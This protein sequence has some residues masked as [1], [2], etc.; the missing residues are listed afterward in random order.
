M[1]QFPVEPKITEYFHQIASRKKIPLNGTFE[2]TPVCNMSCRMC[3]VRMTKAQQEAIR[4]LHTAQEWLELGRIARDKG[5]LYLLLTGGEPFLRED[6]RQILSG[7]HQLGL[8]ISVNTNGTLIDEQAVA[9]LKKTPPVRFNITL[10]GASNE[11]YA[12]LCGNPNGFTQVTKAIRLLREAGMLVKLNCSL[13]PYNQ[14]DLEDII[15]FAKEEKLII[16]ASSYM[17]PPMRRAPDMIG[18]NDRFTPQEAAYYTAKIS[19]LTNGA[20]KFVQLVQENSLP[21]LGGESEEECQYTEGEGIRCRA[22]KC[23]FWVTWDGRMMPCGMMVSGR[24][25]NVFADGFEDAWR[26]VTE[27]SD[28]IRLAPQCRGCSKRSQCQACAAMALTETGAFDKIPEYRCAMTKAYPD[29]CRAVACEIE[30]CQTNAAHEEKK[31]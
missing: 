31:L 17:F 1:T 11:T 28:E 18:I 4:P 22:G 5:M 13:T 23:S 20:E 6:F 2:L 9:W 30:K 19:A 3:Y 27:I 29:A 12:H 15:A 14:Q 16:Q 26:T 7:L 25:K 24:E 21:G 10:Y 8:I